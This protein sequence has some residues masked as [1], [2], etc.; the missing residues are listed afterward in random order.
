VFNL[1]GFFSLV[2]SVSDLIGNIEQQSMPDLH[3]NSGL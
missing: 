1:Y 3:F 2:F